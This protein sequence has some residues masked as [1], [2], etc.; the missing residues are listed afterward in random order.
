[1][2][3]IRILA[4]ADL[5]F[6]N[7]NSFSTYDDQGVP[8]R[9]RLYMKLADDITS[10][11]T[12]YKCDLLVVA[13]DLFQTPT[14]R[15]MVSNTVI[16]FFKKISS[17]GIDILVTVG[18]HDCDTKSMTDDPIHSIVAATALKDYKNISYCFETKK[19]Q[20]NNTEILVAPWKRDGYDVKGLPDAEVFVSHGLVSGSTDRHGYQF[21]NGFSADELCEKFKLSII[22]DLHRPQSM[23]RKQKDSG[24]MAK[25]LVPG[26]PIQNTWKDS[27]ECCL[28][29]CDLADE[30]VRLK[31]IDL[32]K[33]NPNTYH[34]FEYTDDISV[35]DDPLNHYKLF[36]IKRDDGDKPPLFENTNLSRDFD[37]YQMMEQVAEVEQ[38][39]QVETFKGIIKTLLDSTTHA[40]KIYP[41]QVNLKLLKVRNFLSIK[42]LD[43]D[44]EHMPRD[45]VVIGENG[46]GKTSMVE[47][48]YWVLTG[49][50]TKKIP[51]S[52][53]A[54]SY[55]EDAPK[56]EISFASGG[57]NYLIERGRE[58]G[59]YL[60]LYNADES[61][62]LDRASMRETQE[63]VYNILGLS[64]SDISLFC[65]FSTNSMMNFGDLSGSDKNT[66]LGRLVGLEDV[67]RIQEASKEFYKK[68]R[69]S[70]SSIQAEMKLLESQIHGKKEELIAISKMSGEVD[71]GYLDAELEEAFNK[72][73]SKVSLPDV[74]NAVE[75]RLENLK[76]SLNSDTVIKLEKISKEKSQRELNLNTYNFD[77]NALSE[78]SLKLKK[79]IKSLSE[80]ICHYC[81]QP[82]H[83]E[84]VLDGSKDAL[85]A[86]AAKLTDVIK[87]SNLV[88]SELDDLAK[89]EESL[90]EEVKIFNK[91]TLE[92]SSLKDLILK[93][94]DHISADIHDENKVKIKVLKDD[95]R[96]L[97]ESLES[98]SRLIPLLNEMVEVSM[99]MQK[100]LLS[101]NGILIQ[102]L[103]EISC[104]ALAAEVSDITKDSRIG[105]R[106]ETGKST[107]VYVKFID[108]GNEV[109]LGEMSGGE[110][111]V[112][113]ILI[114][115]AINNL[116]AKRY[117]L[118]SG[119][120]GLL[121]FDEVFSHLDERYTDI[122]LSALQGS[123][124]KNRLAIS[125]D[126]RVQN[127]FDRRIHVTNV[128][129]ISD[130]EFNF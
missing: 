105:M 58:E 121:I 69:E 114:M 55:L 91:S 102:K 20:C 96:D 124:T 98:K 101:R 94:Q 104:K 45:V 7:W 130:Y 92:I 117:S 3:E 13:G 5:H 35:K 27:S 57:V 67:E 128:S 103:N 1:M 36:P 24:F 109:S 86:L 12:K 122:A 34:K 15:P 21:L 108:K 4:T 64:E 59:S 52:N 93:I 118:E 62:Q 30:N 119:I 74:K 14:P 125:H 29:V 111:R 77:K 76:N 9:L 115:I 110:R 41:K 47:A 113:D 60:H 83:D 37:I 120:L 49:K 19:M 106:V 63:D 44:F 54:N 25:V 95:V 2:S 123:I 80:G 79:E 18:Q 22:G 90:S 8:S 46:S 116:F 43:L 50:F 16:E 31:R 53:I 73:L 72:D 51:V 33:L 97:K 26:S 99:W 61:K 23:K 65:Y 48:L 66:L 89:Q 70:L 107:E 78:K 87:G 28:W 100:S 127:M 129:G 42:S 10:V 38:P 6:H 56:V 17:T 81:K 75:R 40:E 68:K 112:V 85:K 39:E 11:I 88:K 32:R 126:V 71:R 84:K 82:F